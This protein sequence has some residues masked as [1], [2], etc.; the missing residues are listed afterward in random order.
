MP[1]SAYAAEGQAARN[2]LVFAAD[3]TG[4]PRG[5]FLDAQPYASGTVLQRAAYGNYVFGVYMENAGLTLS[6]ALSA[7][8]AFADLSGAKYGANNGPMDPNYPSL[9][10]ANVVNITAGFLQGGDACHP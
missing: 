6:Q 5:H 3:V 7:A 1:P 9:P 2:P 8:N 4:W 10:A